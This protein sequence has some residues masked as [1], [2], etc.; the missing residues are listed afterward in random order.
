MNNTISLN[1][2]FLARW[3]C[4]HMLALARQFEGANIV[5][6][7]HSSVSDYPTKADGATALS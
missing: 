2:A 6:G 5:I 7:N 4:D 1:F 3:I